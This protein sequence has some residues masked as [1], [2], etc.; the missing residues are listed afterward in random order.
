MAAPTKTE[1]QEKAEGALVPHLLVSGPD[2]H[3]SVELPAGSTLSVGRDEKADIRIPDQRAS[4]YHARLHIGETVEIEDLGS[5]NGTFVGPGAIKPNQRVPLPV[6]VAAVI[7]ATTLVVRNEWVRTPLRRPHSHGY[8]YD[9]LIEKCA[10]AE[11]ENGPTF[12]LVRI[13]VE[14]D[15]DRV[16][17][18]ISGILRPGDLLALYAPHEFEVL[19]VDSDLDTCQSLAVQLE[20]AITEVGGKARAGMAYFPRDGVSPGEIMARACS[21]VRGGDAGRADV[22]VQDAAMREIFRVAERAAAGNSSVLILG[23]TGV[24]KSV[25]AETIHKS[26]SR[27]AKS[28]VCI[29]CAA[30][31]E[32]LLDSEL[33]GHEKGAFTGAGE[34]R[35]GRLE[36][37][38][39]GTVFLDEIG[40]MSAPLQ[41][42]LL[43][44]LQNREIIR[45]GANRPRRIDV[46]FIAATNRDLEEEVK[47]RRFRE[48]LFYRLAVLVLRLPALRE[49]TGEI[50]PMA[51]RF[52]LDLARDAGRTAPDI[53]ADALAMLV[54]YAW[55][56]NIRELRNTMERALALCEGETITPEY[57]PLDKMRSAQNPS[58]A[59]LSAQAAAK[60]ADPAAAQDTSERDRILSALSRCAGNQ[61]RAAELLGVSRRT[62]CSWLKTYDIP[63][64]RN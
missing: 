64:P 54:D 16:V 41:A 47:A 4:R 22:V 25:L 61:T 1:S 59:G 63:R 24:G 7:G 9:C 37:A 45:V 31:A 35:I 5:A 12:A 40:E 44:V 28:F 52:L 43:H 15:S 42:K 32:S 33:F 21:L 20:A 23:E 34:T 58:P 29:N 48:D 53:S 27:A 17:A 60:P 26:S 30:F 10:R 2:V 57:L 3:L 36:S 18:T 55:P 46:R 38:E 8:F 50:E 39:G 49:R 19:L 51:R 62:L 14:G 13:H 56:G 11:G 6:G